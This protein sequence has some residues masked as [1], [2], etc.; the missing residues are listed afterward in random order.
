MNYLGRDNRSRVMYS[1]TLGSFLIKGFNILVSFILVPLLI[2]GLTNY[3]YGIWVSLTNIVNWISFFD[4]GLG[5]GLKNK[6]GSALAREEN[7]LAQE[8]VSTSYVLVTGIAIIVS[9]LFFLFSIFIDWY[10]LLNIDRYLIVD[11]RNLINIILLSTLLNFVLK[12]IDSILLAVQK[13]VWSSL[14]Y[15]IGQIL[16]LI[17]IYVLS[18]TKPQNLLIISVIGLTFL[19]IVVKIIYTNF[20]FKAKYN[21]LKPRFSLFK[22]EHVSSLLNLGLK[23]FII[24]L[25]VLVLFQTQNFIILKTLGASHVTTYNISYKLFT[26]AYMIFSILMIP[27]WSG[28]IEAYA[29][30]DIKW[31]IK[32]IREL[33][34][35]LIFILTIV[36]PI[37]YFYSNSLFSF[38]LKTTFEVDQSIKVSLLVYSFLLSILTIAMHL[39]N[40]IGKINIQLLLYVFST[41]IN[42]PISFYL[43]ER[44]G[45]SGVVWASNFIFLLMNIVLWV[46]TYR[47]LTKSAYG[48]WD[49]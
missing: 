21:F 33:F 35:L 19:P 4:I 17:Y 7:L 42:I 11:L 40:G 31:L 32:K 25:G 39:L 6:L 46:Q 15:L 14:L 49:K 48:I 22:K 37:L 2:S 12:L 47:L 43:C 9:L 23:F 44:Y 24:Q 10:T 41:I 1:N 26:I 28:V 34:V 45:I 38:W 20:F 13:T 29:K 36:T 5:N 18:I 3:E 16:I 27:F 30:N 8:Y